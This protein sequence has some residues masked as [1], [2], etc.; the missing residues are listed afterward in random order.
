LAV[1]VTD[2]DGG[3]ATDTAAVVVTGNATVSMGSGWWLNQYRVGPPDDFTTATLE[4][5]LA[6]AGYFSRVFPDGMTRADA[7]VILFNPAKAPVLDVFEQQLLAAWLNFAN[8]AIS[9]DTPV[10]TG[11][12]RN[13]PPDTTFGA[14]ILA[15][16]LVATNPAST[17]A[18][19][20]AQK[21]IIERIVLR[22][23]N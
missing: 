20:R 7:E 3:S 1:T 9:F 18:E 4:C 10:V 12:N 8:G 15:A 19:I 16:E 14:A 5:Y 22:D 13:A 6:I 11:P 21:D 2:D 23:R 17:E